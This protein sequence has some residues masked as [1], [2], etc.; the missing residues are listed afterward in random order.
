MQ[1]QY[2]LHIGKTKHFWGEMFKKCGELQ[3]MEAHF[4][5]NS[6]TIEQ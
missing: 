3:R 6:Y 4:S 5:K 1:V 2:R